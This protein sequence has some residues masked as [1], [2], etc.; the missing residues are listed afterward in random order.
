MQSKLFYTYI[1]IFVNPSDGDV[2]REF[3]VWRHCLVADFTEEGQLVLAFHQSQVI[4][5]VQLTEL[6]I[7]K[8]LVADVTSEDGDNPTIVVL[9]G[10]N[11]HVVRV[12]DQFDKGLKKFTETLFDCIG[13]IKTLSGIWKP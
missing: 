4:D 6:D 11:L 12:S 1:S 2:M 5:H 7:V 3:V 8:L 13:Y 10:Y 9:S